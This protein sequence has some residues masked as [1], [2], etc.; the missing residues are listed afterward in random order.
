MIIIY[1]SIFLIILLFICDRYFPDKKEGK[2]LFKISEP[3]DIKPATQVIFKIS[4]P[5]YKES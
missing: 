4:N 3:Y 5:T 2:V 1:I